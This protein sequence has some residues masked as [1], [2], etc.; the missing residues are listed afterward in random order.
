M[1]RLARTLSTTA[2][3]TFPQSLAT[4][5]LVGAGLL[6]AC[7]SAREGAGTLAAADTTGACAGASTGT[8]SGCSVEIDPGGESG[9]AW[10]AYYYCSNTGDPVDNGCPAGQY[11][12]YNACS[13]DPSNPGAYAC[14][15]NC[16]AGAI[17][18]G[19]AGV[20]PSTCTCQK[21]ACSKL[22]CTNYNNTQ[23][24]E[25][26]DGCNGTINCTCANGLGC[27]NGFCVPDCTPKTE[28]AACSGQCSGSADDG[29]GNPIFCQPSDCTGGTYCGGNGACCKTAAMLCGVYD[30][31]SQYDD[32]C[33]GTVDCGSGGCPAPFNPCETLNGT[34]EPDG[35][36]CIVPPGN[37]EIDGKCSNGE[38][39]IG[40]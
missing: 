34:P 30:C 3:R 1:K 2:A 4:A 15:Q 19:S 6:A 5:V 35:I 20:N 14:Q 27:E 33:G 10:E 28:Q 39:T 16:V 22:K 9:T 23:C 40:T 7:S 32:G 29:C 13:P 38:C 36:D 12:S 37:P 8:Q 26:P 24:G 18:C 25:L 31:N 11:T 17:Q 21:S